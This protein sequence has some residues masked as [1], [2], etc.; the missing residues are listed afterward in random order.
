VRVKFCGMTNL[1][2]AL[3]AVDLG[4]DYVGFV[5]YPK[6][7]RA[8]EYKKAK[9]IIENIKGRVKTVGVFVEQNSDEVRKTVSFCGLDY[10]QVYSNVEGVDTIRVYRI[11]DS[12]PDKVSYGFVLFDSCTKSVGGSG[13]GFDWELIKGCNYIDRLFLAGGVSFDNVSQAKELGVYGVDLVSSIE[14][15]PGKKDLDK[16]KEFIR[17][18]KG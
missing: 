18:V 6:S 3:Y 11:A 14:K 12:L 4:V 2:D 1:E 7:K 10:A 9:S 8:I 17:I 5:F 16:M 13:V 15:Y